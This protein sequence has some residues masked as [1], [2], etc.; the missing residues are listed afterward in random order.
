[1]L[2]ALHFDFPGLQGSLLKS[3]PELDIILLSSSESD[4][5]LLSDFDANILL[6]SSHLF[7]S[8]L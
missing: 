3:F 5:K 4:S 7:D 6:T 8:N 2:L 1:M